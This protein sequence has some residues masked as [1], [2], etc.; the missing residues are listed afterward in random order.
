MQEII[1]RKYKIYTV[2]TT[3]I[4]KRQIL[5][6]THQAQILIMTHQAQILIMMHQAQILIMT[7]QAQILIM[8]HQGQRRHQD[9]AGTCWFE[10][11]ASSAILCT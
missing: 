1:L 2:N 8:T 7:H 5:I 6:M 11:L 9:G 10:M 4:A 3:L